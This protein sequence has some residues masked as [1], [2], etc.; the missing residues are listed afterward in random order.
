LFGQFLE[1]ADLDSATE[2]LGVEVGDADLL[3]GVYLLVPF[4]APRLGGFVEGERGEG[5]RYLLDRAD[6]AFTV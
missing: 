6:E 5:D 2:G 4:D 1:G 3:V